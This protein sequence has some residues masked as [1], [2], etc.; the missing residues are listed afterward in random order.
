MADL[1]SRKFAFERIAQ[2]DH[3][4]FDEVR[5]LRKS[6]F[7]KKRQVDSLIVQIN[8]DIEDEKT[9]KNDL[10]DTRLEKADA[11]QELKNQEGQIE[12]LLNE[13]D[14]EDADMASRIAAFETGAS[15]RSIPVYH[16]RFRPPL[17]GARLASPF[18]MR[19][20][21]ILHRTRMHTG[22]D[23]ST[24]RSGSPIHAAGDGVVITT[25][26]MRGYGNAIVVDHGGGIATL[27]GHCSR[28]VASPGMHV[29]KG[30]VIAL[31]GAT[32]LAT[33]PHCHFEVRVN[34]RPV[35]PLPY[36]R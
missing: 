16:G 10:T 18:G 25:T 33:G 30:Q 14:Q 19:Y 23:F 15:G 28:F 36:L 4:L 24:G 3:E 8:Q 7:D 17:D 20:H 27:Y 12:T 26:Y 29:V 1:S 34:G 5:R 32:G 22:Q 9:E 21:P 6:V 35:N 11:L 13:L 31:V 2:R